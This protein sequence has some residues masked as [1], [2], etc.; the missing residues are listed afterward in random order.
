M[1]TFYECP[2]CGTEYG[3]PSDLAHCI[4]RCEKKEKQ[5]KLTAEKEARYKEVI[6]AYENF[7]ELRSK[8]VDDYGSFTFKYKSKDEE[9]CASIFKSLGL[10]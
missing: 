2:Y 1:N 5:A 8:Y 7:E 4:L 9:I 10:Y 6:N 3:A